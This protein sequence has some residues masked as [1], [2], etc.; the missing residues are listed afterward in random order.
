MAVDSGEQ[1][2]M[3]SAMA[4]RKVFLSHHLLSAAP[5]AL[6]ASQVE[7]LAVAAVAAAVL[8]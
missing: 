8:H 1:A 3:E 5:T 7:S 2:L 6:L 4:V